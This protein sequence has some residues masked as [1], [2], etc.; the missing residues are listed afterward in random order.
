VGTSDPIIDE[1]TARSIRRWLNTN[2]ELVSIV[3]MSVTAILTAWCG[4]Q[5]AQWTA[6]QT[7]RYAEATDA[8]AESVRASNA[9]E[10]ATSI[11]LAVF[12]AWLDE[13]TDGDDPAAEFIY[14][15]FPDRLRVAADAWLALEPFDNPDAPPSPF[16][17]E[18]YLVPAAVQAEEMAASAAEHTVAAQEATERASEYVLMTVLFATVLFFASVSSK[19]TGI[20]NRWALL[21]LA[22]IGLIGG[23]IVLLTAPSA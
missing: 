6:I 18:E 4:F 8:Q 1:A 17:M 21:S 15:R 13:T 12:I 11:D 14:E 9:A 22:I 16:A 7:E 3:V 20:G 23:S 10:E 19:L 5:G 2:F